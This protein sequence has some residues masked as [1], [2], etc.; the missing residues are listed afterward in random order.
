MKGNHT[1]GY[2][3]SPEYDSYQ[4]ARKRCTDPKN[5]D[6]ANYGGR[7]IEFRFRS[8]PDFLSALGEEKPTPEHTVE[9]IDNN[10]HYEWGNVRWATRSEQMRNQRK[11]KPHSEAYRKKQSAIGLK[12]WADPEKRKKRLAYAGTDEFRNRRSEI[13]KKIWSDPVTRKRTLDAQKA[14]REKRKQWQR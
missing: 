8:F 3:N 12:V 7:G 9:R 6:Y 2:A 11:R 1:H 14:A 13:S 5:K 4:H 10:G